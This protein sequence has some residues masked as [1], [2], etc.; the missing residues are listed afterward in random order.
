MELLRLA[1]KQRVPQVSAEP[2]DQRRMGAVWDTRRDTTLAVVCVVGTR[3]RVRVIGC[4]TAQH[5]LSQHY[6]S[7]A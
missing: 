2:H 3:S 1:A 7:G 4:D 6:E 5:R